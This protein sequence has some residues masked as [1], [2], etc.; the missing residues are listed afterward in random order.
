MSFN[1]I[2]GKPVLPAR[3][4]ATSKRRVFLIGA[5]PSALH[6]RWFHPELHREVTAIAVDNEPEPFWTGIDEKKRIDAWEESV[7]WKATWG[8]VQPCGSLNGSSGVWV[9]DRVLCPL[10][11]RRN[12]TWITDSLDFYC[13]SVGAR[14]RTQTP[15]V[16]H[17]LSKYSIPGPS[18]HEH[19][20]ENTIVSIARNEGHHARLRKELQTAQPE[21]LITLGN[22]ALR[23]IHEVLGDAGMT[24][25]E[26]LSWDDRKYGDRFHAS[27][28]EGFEFD[29][30]PLAHPASPDSYQKAHDR[31]IEGLK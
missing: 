12:E 6:V 3:H 11:I 19:P 17:I 15:E 9:R 29:V 22:A 27:L 7:E 26:K 1:F 23:V 16:Q 8:S 21:L 18:L 24:L 31:W 10:R 20:D 5:Y 13:E 2:F 14:E 30:L 25:P 4:S 28:G